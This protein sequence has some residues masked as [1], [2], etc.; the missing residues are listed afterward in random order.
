M[1]PFER[2]RCSE[3]LKGMATDSLKELAQMMETSNETEN[4]ALNLIIGELKSRGVKIERLT[5][6]ERADAIPVESE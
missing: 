1:T 4:E 6:I 3:Q 5:L 2:K